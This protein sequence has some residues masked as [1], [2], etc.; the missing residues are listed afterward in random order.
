LDSVSKSQKKA[1]RIKFK[2]EKFF[3]E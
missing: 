2:K 3:E 1:K